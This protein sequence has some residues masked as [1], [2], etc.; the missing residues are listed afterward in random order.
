MDK[1][2]SNN[3]GLVTEPEM[4]AWIK[5]IQRRYVTEDAKTQ[6]ANYELE[7]A[8]S[9]SWDYYMERT[10]GSATGWSTKL[11]ALINLFQKLSTI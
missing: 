1:I 3:D 4:V 8:A 5:Y 2:D 7:G 9:M 11:N 6:W 10:Y